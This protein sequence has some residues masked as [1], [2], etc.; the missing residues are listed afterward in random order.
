LSAAS[1]LL[2]GFRALAA[3]FRAFGLVLGGVVLDHLHAVGFEQREHGL[4]FFG[5]GYVL[6]E[7]IGK[8]FE[9]ERFFPF[10]VLEKFRYRGIL[11][12]AVLLRILIA[13]LSR[14]ILLRIQGGLRARIGLPLAFG[15]AALRAVGGFVRAPLF[16]L[17]FRHLTFQSACSSSRIFSSSLIFSAIKS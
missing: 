11:R 6:G 13:R 16:F 5:V 3:A 14:R 17:R 7:K 10:C 9:R 8:L 4:D 12:A 1:E 2:A 15:L